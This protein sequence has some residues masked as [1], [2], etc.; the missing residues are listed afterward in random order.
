MVASGVAM[1]Q[2]AQWTGLAV[3]DVVALAGQSDDQGGEPVGI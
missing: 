1:E 3:E 2:V